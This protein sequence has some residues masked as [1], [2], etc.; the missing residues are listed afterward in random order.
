MVENTGKTTPRI[1]IKV[2][3]NAGQKYCN[4]TQYIVCHAE[5][6]YLICYDVTLIFKYSVCIYIRFVLIAFYLGKKKRIAKSLDTL[7]KMT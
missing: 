7:P 1:L 3:E 6:S 4:N 2:D 5:T